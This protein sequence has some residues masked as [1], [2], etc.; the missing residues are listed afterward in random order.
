MKKEPKSSLRGDVLGGV[1]TFLTMSYIVLVN[2]AILSQAGVPF[3]GALTATVLICVTMSF[4]MGQY[5]RLPFAV[6]PG[7]GLNAFFTFGICIGMGVDWR[8]ALGLTFW[9]GVLFLIISLTPLREA[10][11]RAIPSPLRSASAVG[12]GLFLTFIGFKNM[13]LVVGDP[14]TIVKLGSLDA[15]VIVSL[16]GLALM[17][18]FLIRKSPFSFLIGICSITIVYWQMGWT[19]LPESLWS[20]PDFESALLQLDFGGILELSLLPAIVTIMLT[21]LFDSISTFVGVSRATGLVD[22]N[23]DPKNLRQGLIVDSWATLTA[24][25]FGTSSGTAYIE[26][27]SGIEMGGRTGRAAIVTAIC[28]LPCFFIAPLAS[29]IPTQAT[30]PVLVLVGAL[31][32]R[33]LSEL[34]TEKLEDLIPAFLTIIL[35]PFTFSITQGIIW[36]FISYVAIRVLRGR[37]REISPMLYGISFVCLILLYFLKH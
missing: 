24:G 20:P 28:F 27:A 32:F 12:I 29:A 5:A 16:L 2:P 10:I 34:E 33:N 1:T 8:V 7:M 31:M 11:A 19:Q 14:V 4:L 17:F 18:V 13:G 9:A 25:L 36:G 35:I 6:A 3:S 22:K 23:G 37:F 15:K 30:A 21:D 26:S